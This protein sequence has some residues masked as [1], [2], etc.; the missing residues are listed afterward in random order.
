MAGIFHAYYTVA[1]APAVA[2]LVAIG[3]HTLWRQRALAGRPP[4]CSRSRSRCTA[5]LAF[6]LL[7]RAADWHPWL[8]YL[9]LVVGLAAALLLAGRPASPG[10]RRRAVAGAALVVGLAGPAAYSLATAATPHTGSI[11]SAGP[12]GQ[13][14][15]AAAGARARA[16][17]C[18]S[19]VPPAVAGRLA[20]PA[21]A[22]GGA[23]PAA[24]SR[25]ARPAPR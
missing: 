25:A 22:P 2:A 3:A 17:R 19:A 8:R 18:R 12:A 21:A 9:V 7:G 1:L 20:S 15:P 24:C 16:G 11:P 5:V 14:G 6:A 10:R 4:G 13:G 23:A